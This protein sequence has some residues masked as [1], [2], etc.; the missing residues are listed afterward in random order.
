MDSQY[1]SVSTLFTKREME[2]LALICDT[3]IPSLVADSDPHE[4]Y[5]RC[6]NDLDVPRKLA[7]VIERVSDPG[8]IRELRYF[9]RVIELPPMNMLLSRKNKAFSAMSL[10]QRTALLRS[11]ETSRFN[12]R[13]KAF[14]ALK[15]LALML[16]YSLTDDKSRNPNWPAIGYS[17]PPPSPPTQLKTTITPL[18]ITS[19]TVLYADV[20]V[21]GSGAGGG[22]VADQLSA[23]GL[24]V[25]VLEKGDY[26]NETDFDGDERRSTERFFE[27]YGLLTNRDLS[28]SIL[29]GSMLGGGTVV[30]W[31]ASF[32]TPDTVLHEWARDF[33]V[34]WGNA[35]QDAMD[36]IS[37]RL[38]IKT[39]G[40]INAQNR[41]LETGAAQLG[42]D[43]HPIPRNVRDCQDCGFCNFG[44]PHGAKQS[45]LRT[46]LQDMAARGGRI[47]VRA[48]VDKV[49]VEQGQA[50]GVQA[51]VRDRDGNFHALTVRAGTV[52]VAAGAIHT[53]AILMRSGLGN[54]HIGRNLHLHPTTVTYGLYDDPIR[55]WQGPIMTRV[56]DKFKN[57]DG[58]G[59]GVTMETAPIHPGI[60]ALSLPWSSGLQHKQ[61]M[62]YL[63]HLSNI[64]ILT[65]DTYSGRITLNQHKQPVVEYQ[66]NR[67]DARHTLRGIIESIRIHAAAGAW[68]IGA[69][70][71]IPL[72]WRRDSDLDTYLFAIENMRL[73]PNNFALFSAHQM[74]TCRMAD[75]PAR[76]AIAPSG[77]TFEVK[78]LYVADAS[79]LPTASGVNPM[80][81]IMATA[82]IVAGHIV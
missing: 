80:L 32:R 12:I 25:I 6:A 36:T 18:E 53:P 76:G 19:D 14:Q 47:I 82:Y 74:S 73:K 71:A 54:T 2:T 50:S 37:Q 28:I 27:K 48:H 43:A 78:G 51:T 79:A 59:Y 60:G 63:D 45:T 24:D 77:E 56:V 66:L 8:M 72:T 39:T 3:L 26:H 21:V 70:F 9:L 58:R 31:S 22:V 33:G 81:T 40:K 15:R 46:Y 30:N 69:P 38:N 42:Y 29:A 55:G 64:I 75:S 35:Y 68:Q 5:Q 10:P 20:V 23:A 1:Q 7:L 49:L 4:L 41:V 11:W 44:C 67:Y 34:N 65:R 62:S 13:R 52:V 57:L 16:F 61:I 17:G